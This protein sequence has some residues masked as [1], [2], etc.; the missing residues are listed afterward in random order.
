MF[1]KI[2]TILLP[3]GFSGIDTLH[4]DGHLLI[5]GNI[6]SC[7]IYATGYI[8]V[9]AQRIQ[10][11]TFNSKHGKDGVITL[12]CSVNKTRPLRKMHAAC[13]TFS[14][15]MIHQFLKPSESVSQQ[16]KEII[17]QDALAMKEAFRQK[18]CNAQYGEKRIQM[19]LVALAKKCSEYAL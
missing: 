16:I 18:I 15:E 11:S 4:I 5:T 9:A 2:S 10:K 3:K 13:K 17:A 14:D 8:F 6:N 12:Q 1:Q 19:A 7:T